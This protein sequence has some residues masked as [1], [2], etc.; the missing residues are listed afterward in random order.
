YAFK[1]CKIM[2][3]KKIIELLFLLLIASY[4]FLFQNDIILGYKRILEP[5]QQLQSQVCQTGLSIPLR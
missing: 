3:N 4:I 5:V 2:D 1:N